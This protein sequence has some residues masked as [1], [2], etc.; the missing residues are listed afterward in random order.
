MSTP[1]PG[2]PSAVLAEFETVTD[3]YMHRTGPTPDWVV[4]SFR[5]YRELY[6]LTTGQQPTTRV[7]HTP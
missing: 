7:S 5:L 4:W 1:E 3:A 2:N 6:L